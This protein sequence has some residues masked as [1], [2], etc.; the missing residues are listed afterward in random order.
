M[1]SSSSSRRKP[2]IHIGMPKTATKTLQWRLFSQHSEVFYLGRFDGPQ[3]RKHHQALDCCRDATVQKVMQQIAYNKIFH[4]DLDECR[5]LLCQELK[6]AN[7]KNLVPVWS[8]ESYSTDVFS[9]RRVRARNLKYVFEDATILMVLRHPLVLLESAY[10][11]QLKRDNVSPRLK[12]GSHPYYRSMDDWLE[13]SFQGEILPHLQYGQTV[14]AYVEQFGIENVHVFLFDDLV[15]DEQAFFRRICNVMQ[16]DPEEG[17]RLV[18]GE[19]DNERWTVRQLQILQRIVESPIQNLLFRM[20]PHTW[21]LKWLELESFGTPIH[22]GE[23]ARAP[24]SDRWKKEI[25]KA[26]EPG[27]RW[28]QQHFELP[29]QEY[30]YL[31]E[32]AGA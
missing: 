4:P 9:K 21:R 20:T 12:F 2:V 6:E 31:G 15:K 17:V 1:N 26:A 32:G 23:K 24:I 11:Q 25:F 29:L 8:W 10:F 27:N 7:E 14:Q 13:D 22:P 28:L 5:R 3:F 19:R 30:G 18:Q 16:I